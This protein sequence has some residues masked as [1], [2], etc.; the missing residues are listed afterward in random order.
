MIGASTHKAI[1]ALPFEGRSV[2]GFGIHVCLGECRCRVKGCV[3]EGSACFWVL[4]FE[5]LSDRDCKR[6]S[7]VI[8]SIGNEK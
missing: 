8:R 2:K 6:Y 5:G 7:E 4:R 3:V 1:H